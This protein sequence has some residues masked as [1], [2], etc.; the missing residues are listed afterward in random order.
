MERRTVAVEMRGWL[1]VALAS[2]IFLTAGRAEGVGRSRKVG[3]LGFIHHAS[4]LTPMRLDRLQHVARVVETLKKDG[5]NVLPATA[6][7]Q[8]VRRAELALGGDVQELE[9]LQRAEHL[10][11]RVGVTWKLFEA[12]TQRVVYTV[13]TRA[14]QYNVER[15]QVVSVETTLLAAS[16]ASLLSRPEF[17]RSFEVEELAA[18]TY[19]P[20][21][22]K[23]CSPGP[24]QLP[25]QAEEATRGAVLIEGSN[26]RGSGFFISTDGLVLT[27][28]HV[29][30]H[31]RDLKVTLADGRSSSAGVVRLHPKLDVALLRAADLGVPRC[32][33]LA[34]AI[35][36]LG[37]EVYA[38]GSPYDA[39]LAFSLSRGIVSGVRELFGKPLLQTD[40]PV[41]AGNSG[42]PLLGA[43]GRAL[44]V[45]SR[46]IDVQGIEGIGFG[47]P[48]PAALEALSLVA[49]VTSS[50]ELAVLMPPPEERGTMTDTDDPVPSLEILPAQPPPQHPRDLELPQA[51]TDRRDRGRE[52]L[53]GH[54]VAMR[55]GGLALG[56]AGLVT[57]VVSSASYDK[58]KS[59]RKEYERLVVVNTFGWS[60]T[61]LGGAL[62]GWSFAIAPEPPSVSRWGRARRT[63][64]AAEVSGRF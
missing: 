64:L 37:S 33:E 43:D 8:E 25:R 1:A 40:A 19:S 13:T 20:A 30:A 32:F 12:H 4:N 54:A 38:I 62:F 47:V 21:S 45:V 63:I 55:W 7:E 49:D 34:T 58:N 24:L 18:P 59:T 39:R 2:A 17:Q 22:F 41:N 11:C 31:N 23:R 48:V 56:A 51:D 36:S 5:L 28:A 42:G 27:A 53:P 9:C 16:V 46:K 60:A 26:A 35:P 44:A 15:L 50:A 52:T 14:V 3:F 6:G 61:L 57:A 29:V 10:H